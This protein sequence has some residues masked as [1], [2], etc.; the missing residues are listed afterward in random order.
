MARKFELVA[1]EIVFGEGPRWHAGRLFFSDIRDHAVKAVAPGG[2]VETVVQ[3]QGD[4]SGLGWLPDG[5]LLVVSM[6]DHRLLRLDGTQLT[7]VADLSSHCGGKANDMVVDAQGRA[8]VGN[9]GFDI[10]ATP[11]A[12]RATC[13]VRVRE[14]GEIAE[15]IPSGERVAIACALGGLARRT[16]FLVTSWTISLAEAGTRRGGRIESCEVAV[17]GA[18]W[19]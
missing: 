8:Y 16:L 9:I 19:P 18:G 7:E 10:E 17:P 14:G 1:D 11:I 2:K 4:P 12:P 6:E 15:R 5:R 13:L 3:L